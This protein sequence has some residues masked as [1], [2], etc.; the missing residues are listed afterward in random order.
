MNSPIYHFPRFLFFTFFSKF[1]KKKISYKISILSNLMLLAWGFFFFFFFFFY[2]SPPL[3]SHG[4][5]DNGDH[6]QSCN[7]TL[8]HAQSRLVATSSTPKVNE[9]KGDRR[10]SSGDLSR[11]SRKRIARR[12]AQA[13]TTLFESI[14]TLLETL[15]FTYSETLGKWLIGD[16]AFDINYFMR[17]QV[18]S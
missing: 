5:G 11:S 10:S 16:L 18:C 2:Q 1:R 4:G 7:A 3:S 6:C 12:P 15:W 9:D 8:L 17:R 13:L 14:T